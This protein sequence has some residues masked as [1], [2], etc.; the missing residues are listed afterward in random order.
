MK[1]MYPRPHRR[2]YNRMVCCRSAAAVWEDMNLRGAGECNDD[3]SG[4]WRDEREITCHLLDARTPV[5]SGRMIA[6]QHVLQLDKSFCRRSLYQ[7]ACLR[8]GVEV[9]ASHRAAVLQILL[10][11][12]DDLV[13]FPDAAWCGTVDGS[14]MMRTRE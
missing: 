12:F 13:R 9:R 10:N 1:S 4:H 3:S 2:R 7:M 8:Q 6:G 5:T 11:C 14:A